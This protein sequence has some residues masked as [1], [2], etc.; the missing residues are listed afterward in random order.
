M[1]G[2]V[3]GMVIGII[4]GLIVL[5]LICRELICWYYKINK[6]SSQLDEQT[7][8]LKQLLIHFGVFN[9]PIHNMEDK[10]NSME[11]DLI[12]LNDFVLK[13]NATMSAAG[14]VD[15]KKGNYLKYISTVDDWYFIETH[16]KMQGYCLSFHVAKKE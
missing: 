4:V 12:A 7:Q 16:D 6:L 5:F 13:E 2:N 3:W 11:G 8:L 1:A 9:S 14:T 15:V 10:L